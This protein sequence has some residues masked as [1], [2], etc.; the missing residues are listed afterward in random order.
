MTPRTRNRAKRMRT[1]LATIAA[2]M[3]FG[4][5]GCVKSIQPPPATLNVSASLTGSLPANPLQWRVI[6]S[7]ADSSAGTMSTLYG[8]DA[9]VAYARS[10]SAHDYPSG[11]AVAL[12]TW[13]ERDDPRW[14]GAKIPHE[15]R[16]VEFVFVAQG[17]DGKPAYSYEKYEG[18]PLQ[19]SQPDPVSSTA[20]STYLL[21]QRSAVF[22]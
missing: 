19:K 14:F 10:N 2:V 11:S 20:R 22:P 12:V 8:N 4:A 5:A 13:N 9:A 15:V 6:T 21:S 7:M 17:A 16:T 3:L 18:S 1:M